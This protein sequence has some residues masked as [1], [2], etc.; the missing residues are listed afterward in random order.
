MELNLNDAVFKDPEILVAYFEHFGFSQF[1]IHK[2]YMT[3]GRSE[4]GSPTSIVCYFDSDRAFVMD[5]PLGISGDIIGFIQKERGLTFYEAS[6]P[7]KEL[8]SGNYENGKFEIEYAFGGFFK[9][10]PHNSD[11][12]SPIEE[13]ILDGFEVVGNQRF[14][15]DGISYKTQRFFEIG[16]LPKYDLITI[17][18]RDEKGNLVGVKARYNRDIERGS[19]YVHLV[20]C[21]QGF[22]LY[23]YSYNYEYLRNSPE[24]YVFEAEKSVMQAYNFGVRNCISLGGSEISQRQVELLFELSPKRIILMLD[25]GLLKAKIDVSLEKLK[26]M[27]KSRYKFFRMEPVEIQYWKPSE[28]TQPKASPTDFGKE[29]FDEILKQEIESYESR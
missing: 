4:E 26:E 18:L 20:E 5:Y 14:K 13:S 19:K 16:Y 1:K 25:E 8:V 21:S 27:N 6:S 2:N 28:K 22:L 10:N 9:N 29:R 15:E 17:P 23:G 11:F 24:I 3:F 7:L 12:N